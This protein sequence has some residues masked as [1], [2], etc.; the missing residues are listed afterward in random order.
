MRGRIVK[1]NCIFENTPPPHFGLNVVC[2]MGGGGGGGGGGVLTGHYGSTHATSRMYN[3][4]G[5]ASASA[6]I[7][8]THSNVANFRSLCCHVVAR[9]AVSIEEV[10]S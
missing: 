6:C 1:T 10:D 3:I 2:K 4:V 9:I 5:R 7:H 8:F